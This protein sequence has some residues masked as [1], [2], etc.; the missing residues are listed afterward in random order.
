MAEMIKT[1]HVVCRK[2]KYS[3]F[4][5][6]SANMPICNYLIDTGKRRNCPLGYCDKYEERKK[7]R[8][9]TVKIE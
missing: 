2:C 8:N 5:H 6:I 3:T 7:S 1:T 9:K 4:E